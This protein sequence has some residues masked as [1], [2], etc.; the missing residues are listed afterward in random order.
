MELLEAMARQE[1]FYLVGTRPARN[2]NP[3]DI[4][5]GKFARAHGAIG[6]DGRFAKFPTVQVGFDAMRALLLSAYANS[7]LEQMLNHYAPPCENQTNIYLQRVCE[8]TGFKPGDL[9]KSRLLSP[10]PVA[11]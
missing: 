3:G 6:T 4:E 1:G 9:V 10:T 5:D 8:W 7:T 11:A 2:N